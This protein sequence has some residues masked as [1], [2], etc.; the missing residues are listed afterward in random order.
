MATIK[1]LETGKA[2]I[3]EVGDDDVGGL[4][5][6]LAYRFLLALF[7]FFIF[8]TAL[9]GLVATL[10]NVANPA[11]SIVNLMGANLP[12]ETAGLLVS[13]L[14]GVIGAS[15]SGILSFGIL[16]TLWAATGGMKSIMKAMNRAYEVPE[17]RSFLK[18]NLVAIGL[19]LLYSVFAFGAFAVLVIGEFFARQVATM[20]GLPSLVVDLARW[21]LALALISG[22]TAVIYW[23]APNMD[24][25]FK[26]VSPGSILFTV[27]WLVATALFS[28]YVGN[29][30]SYNA[31]YG[32]LGGFVILLLW[33]YITGY[34]LVL[35][36][37][38]N[39]IVDQQADPERVERRRR[40]KYDE[41]SRSGRGGDRSERAGSAPGSRTARRDQAA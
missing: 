10:V 33:F 8:L 25:E 17:S 30:G 21:A 36:A 6:E 11:E 4:A 41:A 23:A 22:M 5:A 14:D 20:L 35:G 1:P 34:I 31:T 3:R 2:L 12:P 9:G 19:T 15:N 26:W 40:E 28:F 32:A 7:P 24:L 29:F 13:Q 38:L 27:G 18:K 16:A 39:A 37:E